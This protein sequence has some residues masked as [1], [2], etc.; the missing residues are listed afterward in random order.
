MV[1]GQELHNIGTNEFMSI[2][3]QDNII[4]F[5][6]ESTQNPGESDHQKSGIQEILGDKNLRINI[7]CMIVVFISASFCYYLISQ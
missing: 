5:Q 7:V 3:R 6:T 1:S 2:K 4:Q